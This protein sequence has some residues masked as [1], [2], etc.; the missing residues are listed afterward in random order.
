MNSKEY[1]LIVAGGKGRRF[2]SNVP[3]QFVE[4]NGMPVLMHTIDAFYQYD[5]RISIILVLPEE[6]IPA[7][8]S[9]CVTYD[10]KRD[11]VVVA[12]G[13][14]RFQSVRNGLAAIA[15]DGLVAI[16]DGV[17]P[18]ITPDIIATSFRVAVDHGAAI[19]AVDMKE[20]LRMI[21]TTGSQAVDR[22]LYK[23]VQTPQ[24]FRVSLVKQAYEIDEDPT[25]TDDASVVEKSGYKI[26]L[27][28][29]NYENIKITTAGDLIL[30]QAVLQSRQN[31]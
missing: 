13:S 9:L 29:G 5:N 16:H 17:R 21:N 23:L 7:W 2:G 8:Q 20:S 3:K 15:G 26:F 14:S 22:S 11:V 6:D 1:A 28:E 10:F 18:L 4:L 27:F 12:G 30:A 31:S 19:A 24:T 25:L